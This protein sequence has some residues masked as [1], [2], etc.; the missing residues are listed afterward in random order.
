MKTVYENSASDQPASNRSGARG[1]KGASKYL[2]EQYA[3]QSKLSA[4]DVIRQAHRLLQ[5][6]DAGLDSYFDSKAHREMLKSIA[7]RVSDVAM[8]ALIEAWLDVATEESRQQLRPAPRAHREITAP[9]NESPEW[10]YQ[11]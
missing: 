3:F 5:R 10:C 11:I 6:V 2:E 1:Q 9:E 4:P 8:V 7:R